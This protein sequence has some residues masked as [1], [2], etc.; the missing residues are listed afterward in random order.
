MS[1]IRISIFFQ[2]FN[3]E[4]KNT[5]YLIDKTNETVESFENQMEKI[6]SSATLFELNVPD[7]RQIRQVRHD[8]I[9]L[10]VNKNNTIF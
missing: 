9:L 4:C 5:Y 7:F 8:L 1:Y 2:L 10:K 6:S 3:A